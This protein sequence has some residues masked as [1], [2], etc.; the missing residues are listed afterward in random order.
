MPGVPT[1]TSLF[2]THLSKTLFMLIFQRRVKQIWPLRIDWNLS[3]LRF[4]G[5]LERNF[6]LC[7]PLSTISFNTQICFKVFEQCPKPYDLLRHATNSNL[8][9]EYLIVGAVKKYDNTR[10]CR[11]LWWRSVSLAIV[12]EIKHRVHD[13]R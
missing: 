12:T 8:S 11:A 3:V 6:S 5:Q 1:R 4:H 2:L 10:S 13:K 7:S 9:V